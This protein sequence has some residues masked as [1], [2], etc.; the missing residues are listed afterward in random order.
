MASCKNDFLCNLRA[1]N[2]SDHHEGVSLFSRILN[3]A[4]PIKLIKIVKTTSED[5]EGEFY[6]N[7]VWHIN[8]A[9]LE[10][11]R[12]AGGGVIPL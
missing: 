9:I 4:N 10:V 7:R 6:D 12:G 3:T 11:H 5:L 8:K 2:P 1:Y